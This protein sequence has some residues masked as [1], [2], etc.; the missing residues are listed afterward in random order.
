VLLV[1]LA[2]LW[3]AV[4]VPATLGS[5]TAHHDDR[6]M[7]GFSTA[8]RTLSRRS[9][10][11]QSDSRRIVVPT[12]A[13]TDARRKVLAA[14]RRRRRLLLSRLLWAGGIT[15]GLAVVLGGPWLAV[16]AAV[17]LVLVGVIVFLRREA[18]RTEAEQRAER[19]R[20]L[21]EREAA[22]HAAYLAAQ[23]RRRA[24]QQSVRELVRPVELPQ[25]R[26]V[27]D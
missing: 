24:E 16:H 17:D 14:R 25:R 9:A 2:A 20:L 4:L 3:A 8:M 12:A 10:G 23:A 6:T 7:S 21:A 27:N 26:A 5:R 1:V 18:L 11:T 19:R 22:Q 15:L 13:V